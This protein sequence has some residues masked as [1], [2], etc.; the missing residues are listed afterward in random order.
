MRASVVVGDN[1]SVSLDAVGGDLLRLV[2]RR[3][4]VAH[5]LR[6]RVRVAGRRDVA[7][8]RRRSRGARERVRL[9]AAGGRQLSGGGGETTPRRG[10]RRRV[11][12]ELRRRGGGGGRRGRQRRVGADG[13]AG[14]GDARRGHVRRRVVELR[15]P[16][17]SRQQ[18]GASPLSSDD[19]G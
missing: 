7:G 12:E 11:V 16:A 5:R 3:R 10:G 15:H 18:T 2:V 6:H 19:D 14:D 17:N 9:V 4:E 13:S 8:R 1:T